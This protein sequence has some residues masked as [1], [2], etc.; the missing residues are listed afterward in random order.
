MKKPSDK[1]WLLILC[2]KRFLELGTNPKELASLCGVTRATI[3]RW[4]R[5]PTAAKIEDIRD[6]LQILGYTKE[7]AAEIF[8][9]IIFNTWRKV[10]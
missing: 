6:V 3:D 7:E 5:N 2:K 8:G 1:L 10:A 9:Q 4:L